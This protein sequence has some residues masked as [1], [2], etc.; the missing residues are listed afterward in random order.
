MMCN[1]F[2]Y[3]CV[4]MLRVFSYAFSVPLLIIISVHTKKSYIFGKHSRTKQE[5]WPNRHIKLTEKEN[6]S[7]A[8]QQHRIRALTKAHV[9]SCTNL[10]ACTMIT[11]WFVR[12]PF[13]SSFCSR[14]FFSHWLDQFS[15]TVK[16]NEHRTC[17]QF[18]AAP[19][20]WLSTVFVWFVYGHSR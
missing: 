10:L 17:W 20:I 7:K 19:L 14:C 9:C 6:N 12:A 16:V 4:C 15:V 3:M 5:H 18:F 2:W 8:K 11:K 1:F 13:F